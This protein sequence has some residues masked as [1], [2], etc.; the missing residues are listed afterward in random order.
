MN[1][2]ENILAGGVARALAV[3]VM[4]PLDTIKSRLQNNTKVPY[5]FYHGWK[6]TVATQ[7]VYGM[8]VFGAYENI[9]K[10]LISYYPN[11]SRQMIYIS[12]AII[13]DTIGSIYLT[14]CEVIKQNIQIGKYTTVCQAIKH[15]G[16]R[17]LYKGYST[18]LLRDV[19]FRMIQMPLY[20]TLKEHYDNTC[21][22]GACAGMT[23]AA[24][25]NPLDVIKTRV[26]CNNA[27][28][29]T[30]TDLLRG[31]PFR[32]TYLGGMSTIF[33]VAYEKIKLM[34]QQP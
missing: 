4:Y 10:S 12:S 34:V 19:P 27:Y 31:L 26:M 8:L 25:T 23:A 7:T 3:S 18:L 13:C 14:P 9:K 29:L 6:Y 24:V 30:P 33:F 17:G 28:R 1:M 22:V 21:I 11:T 20:D 16:L 32:V 15:L 2:D 5:S